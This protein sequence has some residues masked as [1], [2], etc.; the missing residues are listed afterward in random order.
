MKK[1]T[2]N[3]RLIVAA[4]FKPSG[5]NGR[6]WVRSKVL[7]LADELAGTGVC[8]KVNSIL[9]AVGYDLIDELHERELSVFAD[10]KL[11]DIGNTLQ[12]DGLMLAEAQPELLTVACTT[13]TAAVAALKEKLPGTE[14]L[15]VTVLTTFKDQDVERMFLASIDE[16]VLRLARIGS[17]G[18]LDGFICSPAEATVLRAAFPATMT[19]NT[20]N[21]RPL[22]SVLASDDQNLERVMTPAKAIKAGV[23]RIVVGRPI[24]EAAD[25]RA[26]VLRILEELEEAVG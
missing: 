14:V 17:D 3:E 26:A 18:S 16:A 9:R 11:F 10:L 1:L 12:T 20:P 21:V 5:H 2:T 23:D 4:D 19:I 6:Q 13:G 8:I 15:G 25:H 22:W 7:K 24:L